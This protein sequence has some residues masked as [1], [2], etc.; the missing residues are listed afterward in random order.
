[1]L[2]GFE[3]TRRL[4]QSKR[5]RLMKIPVLMLVADADKLVRPADSLA[6]AAMLPDVRVVRFGP[7]SA[8]EILREVDPV[9][10]RALGEIDIFLA[11]RAQQA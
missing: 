1:V 11:A 10:N 4:R 3:S 5:I 8:H 2:R 7:E 6:V 9:R